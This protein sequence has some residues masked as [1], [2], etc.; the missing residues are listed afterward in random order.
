MASSEIRAT[1]VLDASGF[2]QALSAATRSINS[3]CNQGASQNK[4]EQ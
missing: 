3:M 1:L 4:G 2:T